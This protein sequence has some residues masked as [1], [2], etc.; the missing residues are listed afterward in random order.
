M[1]DI[2]ISYKELEARLEGLGQGF[3]GGVALRGP[4]SPASSL[5]SARAPLGLAE[6]L[7]RVLAAYHEALSADMACIAALASALVDA[8]AG[9]AAGMAGVGAGGI[10]RAGGG[11]A[12]D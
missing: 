2:G 8:D 1:T 10:R 3:S 7:N 11:P 5:A 12:G 4:T 9:L 6:R